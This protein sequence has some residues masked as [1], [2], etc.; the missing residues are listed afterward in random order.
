MSYHVYILTNHYMSV[1]Y[2]GVTSDLVK[3]VYQH[4]KKLLDG[5]TKR[6][7]VD[8]L[9]YFEETDDGQSEIARKKQL[10]GWRRSRK[11]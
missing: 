6:Y 11:S 7:H 9:I 1:L 3:R 4:K 8:R 2:I 5:F 10:K